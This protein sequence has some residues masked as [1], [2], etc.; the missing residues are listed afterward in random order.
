MTNQG[1]LNCFVSQPFQT[2]TFT[3]DYCISEDETTNFSSIYVGN[4]NRE[5]AIEST[6]CF[7]RW[8][9]IHDSNV[10]LYKLEKDIRGI[11]GLP[12]WFKTDCIGGIGPKLDIATYFWDD[13]KQIPMLHYEEPE[14]PKCERMARHNRP[15]KTPPTFEWVTHGDYEGEVLNYAEQ[16]VYLKKGFFL[17]GRAGV[18]KTTLANAVISVLEA[19]NVNYA[20]FSTTHVSKNIMGDDKSQLRANKSA[21]TIDSLYSKFTKKPHIVQPILHICWLR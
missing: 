11:G 6:G 12:F 1:D 20:A 17:N 7:I 8:E 21:N 19:R 3:N 15:R 2:K 14:A 4:F 18:G 9:V 16:L 10:F 5:M 13:D